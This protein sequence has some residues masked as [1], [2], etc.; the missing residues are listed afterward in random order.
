MRKGRDSMRRPAA[1]CA[2]AFVLFFIVVAALLS[3]RRAGAQE[4]P[5]IRPPEIKVTRA[6]YRADLNVLE[7]A[8]TVANLSDSAIYVDCQGQPAAAKA[9]KS[10]KLRFAASDAAAADT[11]RP[12][13]VGARQGYQGHRRIFGLGPDATGGPAHPADPLAAARLAVEMAVYPERSEG[14]GPAWVLERAMPV[15]AKPFPLAKQGAR[16][17]PPKPIKVIRPTAD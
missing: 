7:F 8:F 11:A 16:P 10:L 13:R 17:P 15:A 6:V 1:R 9:G 2:L 12:Q 5:E 4:P 14:E 3:P